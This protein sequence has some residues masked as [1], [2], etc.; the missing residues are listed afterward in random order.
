MS[1]ILKQ[2]L[3][4][5]NIKEAQLEKLKS[6]FP[7][8][9]TEGLKVDW[10]KLKLTLGESVDVGKERYG[11]M[12]PGKAECF[13]TIQ[14][15]S[16]GT[17]IPCR[18][19]SIDFDNTQ[20]LFIEGDNLEVL[21]LLQKS[22]LGKIKF[23]YFDPPY[24]TGKDFIY[25]DNYSESLDTYLEYTGQISP[26]GKKFGTNT[27]TDGRFH[28]KWL[29]MMYP[30]LVLAKNLLSDDG[31][32]FIS[33]DDNEVY[34]LRS[35]CNE[36][37]GED[38]FEAT[39]IPIVNP[40]GRDYKQV[41]ITNEYM[42]V[43]SKSDSMQLNELEKEVDFQ[44]NDLLGGYNVR[45][46]RNRNPKFHSG[47]RPNLFYP[48]Y[49]NEN[50]K[51][52][53]GYCNVSIERTEEFSIEVKPYN[54]VGR[55][56]VWRWGIE[57]ARHNIFLGDFEKSQILAK[58]KND[59]GW[60]ILEKNRRSTTKVK[61]VWDE[62]E[63]RTENGTREIR[64]LFNQTVF[65]HPKPVELIKK[66]VKIGT[67]EED[68]ILDI[69]AGSGSTAQA[70]MEQNANDGLNRKFICIQIPEPTIENSEAYKAGY[71]N[72]SDIT[73][74]RI[75]RVSQKI[76]NK[77]SIDNTNNRNKLDFF[78]EKDEV[79][80][81]N[82]DLGYKVFKL[83]KSNFKL[84]DS[85]LV[86]EPAV[87][88]SKLFEHIEHITQETEQEAIFYE[89]LLKSGFELTSCIEKRTLFGKTIFSIAEGQL[90]VCLE[91]EVDLEVIKAIATMRPSRA[92]FLDNSFK[93]PNA[94][95]LKTNAVQIM[96]SNGVLNFR[97]I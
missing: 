60:I 80:K 59:G 47:N 66:A 85:A 7:E 51:D 43:Y 83:S 79:N 93:G 48:F 50:V 97:T 37:F 72:I 19:E 95:A 35:I 67:N 2:E 30:R 46:L 15:P 74:A 76:S 14:E 33:I 20:N 86:K 91:D 12:W 31:V 64:K 94:D 52:A 61:S 62:T 45:D 78:K 90:I 56:S 82:L 69:F 38:N 77:I 13:K 84:W 57:K 58:K 42:L 87:I 40:G 6:I 88:Q 89:L 21:K 10:E 26:D 44:F 49:V 24:N 1:E 4:S 68:I 17:L 73:K 39:I 54:S 27:D 22:Y 65:D 18:E 23:M 25:P 71:M 75:E 41:A 36:I 55:E 16:I 70:V 29:N 11:M 63:M 28:S 8:V 32:I 3:T 81:D 9:F 53:N 34:N 96:K 5:M 92:V